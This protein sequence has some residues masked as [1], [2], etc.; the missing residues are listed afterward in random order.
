[1]NRAERTI[2]VLLH[3]L[4]NRVINYDIFCNNYGSISL[5]TFQYILSDLKFALAEYYHYSDIKF[6]RDRNTYVIVY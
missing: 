4:E 5:R 1:M 6:N 2:I 3:L